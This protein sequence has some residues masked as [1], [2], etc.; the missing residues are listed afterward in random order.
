MTDKPFAGFGK[1]AIAV[2][3]EVQHVVVGQLGLR[4]VQHSP[5][6][7][8][9]LRIEDEER[10]AWSGNIPW[11]LGNGARNLRVVYVHEIPFRLTGRRH[12]RDRTEPAEQNKKSHY[13][14]SN[15]KPA[16]AIVHSTRSA[17]PLR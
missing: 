9:S 14:S 2:L 8:P 11:F 1:V 12:R 17:T 6:M 7:K 10:I 4:L 13:R 16:Y 15:S 3:V 5:D